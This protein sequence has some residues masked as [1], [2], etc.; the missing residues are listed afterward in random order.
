LTFETPDSP[1]SDADDPYAHDVSSLMTN[2]MKSVTALLVYT[3]YD[4]GLE[5]AAVRAMVEQEFG[6][7][8]IEQL[9][10]RQYCAVIRYLVDMCVEEIF[11]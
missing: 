8:D 6:V 10:R 4:R 2:E 9:Q 3:A 7:G 5:E 11:D 1:A